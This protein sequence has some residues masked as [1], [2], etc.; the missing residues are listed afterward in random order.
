M[1]L[2]KDVSPTINTFYRRRATGID[3]NF[4]ADLANEL[5]DLNKNQNYKYWADVRDIVAA[6]EQ[7][8]SKHEDDEGRGTD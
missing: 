8:I 3:E 4:L 5:E 1:S 7:V 2:N 6:H